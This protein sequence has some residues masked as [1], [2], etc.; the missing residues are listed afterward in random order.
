MG[1]APLLLVPGLMCDSRVFAEQ[2]AAFARAEVAKYGDAASLPEM[3]QRV[4]ENAPQRFVLLG[5]SMGA[6]VALEVYRQAPERVERLALLSASTS[7]A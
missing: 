6:R 4:L 5:H 3:A 7:P 1:T 2:V